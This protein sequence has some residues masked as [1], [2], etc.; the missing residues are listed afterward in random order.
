M[1]SST[2]KTS[3][4]CLTAV[5]FLAILPLPVLAQTDTTEGGD[6]SGETDKKPG[7]T[8]I[9]SISGSAEVFEAE[10]QP[11]KPAV[12]DMVLPVGS[13]IVTG[14]GCFVDLAMSNGALFQLQ[15][16]TQF[17]IGEFEQ[18]DYQFV[19]NNGAVLKPQAAKQFDGGE[20]VL[21]QLDASAEAFNELEAEPTQSNAKFSLGYGTMVGYSKRL[22]PGSSMEIVTPVG[23]AGIRGTT[24]RLTVQRVGPPGSNRFNVRLD[25]PEGVV[26]FGNS[27]GTRAVTV[28]NGFT[29]QAEAIVEAPGQVRIEQL[30]NTPMSAEAVALLSAIVNEVRQVQTTFTAI[31]GN[32]DVLRR[33]EAANQA[34]RQGAGDAGTGRPVTIDLP[35]VLPEPFIPGGSGAIPVQPTPTPTPTPTP[36]PS[37]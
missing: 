30:T 8:V 11:G 21:T 23:V 9:V 26:Q 2:L 32:P 10:G 35:P 37:R 5:L 27:E 22:S 36:V 12:K 18:E 13:T 17:G 15:E 19:F 7:I 20:A 4:S 28:N 3:L 14:P 24:W 29:L 16:N 6:T 25:V 31:Q 33:V 1:N 34:A